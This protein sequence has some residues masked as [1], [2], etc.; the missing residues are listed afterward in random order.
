MVGIILLSILMTASV[1][2]YH[3]MYP[4]TTW[5]YAIYAVAV[6]ASY[7]ACWISISNN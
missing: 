2:L 7:T 3:R 1:V 5:R 6:V 4:E